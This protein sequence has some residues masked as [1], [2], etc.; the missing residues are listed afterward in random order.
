[1]KFKNVES[2]K[3]SQ[4]ADLAKQKFPPRHA[5][6]MTTERTVLCPRIKA[7]DHTLHFIQAFRA[8]RTP[9]TCYQSYKSLRQS[10]PL[11]PLT[12]FTRGWI[13]SQIS[14]PR[15]TYSEQHGRTAHLCCPSTS[16]HLRIS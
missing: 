3:L 2:E 11:A 6:H 15:G 14:T 8:S 7:I 5:S 12:K 1:M 4:K 13:S 10:S 9:Q 16:P